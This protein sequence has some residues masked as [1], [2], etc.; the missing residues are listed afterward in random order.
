MKKIIVLFGSLLLAFSMIASVSAAAATDAALKAGTD[1]VK[2][3][4]KIT[5]TLSL[6]AADAVTSAYVEVTADAGLVL[7]PSE[8]KWVKEGFLKDFNGNEGTIALTSAG[9]F[10][11]E[12]LKL[13]F[14]AKTASTAKQQIQVAVQVRNSSTELLRKTV[15]TNIAIICDNHAFGDWNVSKE[16]TC[17][18]NGERVRVCSVCGMEEEDVIKASGHS[19]GAWSTVK[20]PTCTVNGS[21]SRSCSQCTFVETNGLSAKGHSYGAEVVVKDPTQTETGMKTRTCGSCGDVVEEVIPV[22]GKT[23]PATPTPTSN[24][25]ATPMITPTPT[26]IPTASSTPTSSVGESEPSESNGLIVWILVV[27]ILLAGGLLAVLV[28]KKKKS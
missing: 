26:I 19:L 7:I 6:S 10:N 18:Q 11:G 9:D 12:V 25:T 23:E 21:Q 16:A 2:V 4:D 3:G 28:V 15:S 24:P 8:C 20:A 1:H 14:E 5:V 22:V 17:T 27:A 13:V